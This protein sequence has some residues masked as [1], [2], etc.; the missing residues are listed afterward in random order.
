M[1]R[2]LLLIATFLGSLLP[3]A[4]ASKPNVIFLLADDL[5]GGDLHC[6]GHPYARTP[7]IDSLARDGTRFTQFYATGSTCCPSRTGLMTS[8]F[9]ATYPTYPANGGFADRVTITE[10][11]KKQ[12]YATGHFGKWHIGP[13]QKPGTY[14]IDAIGSADEGQGGKKKRG[15]DRGRD[16]H[17]YDE[18]IKFIEKNKAG[19]F[20]MNVW[21]HISHNPV[22]P[23]DALVKRWSDLK[24]KDGDFPAQMLA[25]FNDAR[26]NGGDLEL[27]DILADPAES[28]NLAAQHP[29][30]VKKLSTQVEAWVAALP[31]EYLKTKDKLD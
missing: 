19:P 2:S 27:Y 24:V 21:G 17:I 16:A 30:I 25:K 12:G 7:H 26:K 28:K 8:K 22:N 15:D 14:G 13:V 18:A 6:Y 3:L 4:A 1:K 5:G 9:P 31:N 20:Y 23:T 10:L 11:L 29:D